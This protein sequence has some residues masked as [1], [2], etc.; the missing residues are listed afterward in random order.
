MFSRSTSLSILSTYWLLHQGSCVDFITECITDLIDQQYGY[1]ISCQFNITATTANIYHIALN[2]TLPSQSTFLFDDNTHFIG[3]QNPLNSY[4]GSQALA[5]W[6]GINISNTATLTVYL[7]PNISITRN[8]RI[9][10][11]ATLQYYS[12]FDMSQNPITLSVE[13]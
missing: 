8:Q 6:D 2:W 13:L 10:S 11:T 5:T 9:S 4:E 7:Q 12:T 3:G 1:N